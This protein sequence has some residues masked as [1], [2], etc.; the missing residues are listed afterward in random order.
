MVNDWLYVIDAI[1]IVLFFASYYLHCYRRGYKIDI[2]YTQLFLGCVLVDQVMLPFA[3]SDLNVISIGALVTAV[4]D[5]LADAFLISLVGFFAILA[6]GALWKLRLGVGLRR[7]ASS[8]LDILP[9]QSR[10]LM[11]SRQL[12][13]LQ[14]VL[15]LLAQFVIVLVY[16]KSSGF[17]FN[18]RKFA[19]EEPSI[20]P[21]ALAISNY[22]IIIASHC[23]ARYMDTKEKSLLACTFFLTCGLLFFGSRG[24]ILGIFF[25]VLLCHLMRL[26][27][28]LKL[29]R[30]ILIFF[31]VLFFGLYVG[32]LR[33]GI[34]SMSLFMSGVVIEIFYGNSFS[35]LRDFSLVLSSW[36]GHLW[37]GQTYLAAA[38]AFV[39]RFLSTYRD[40]WSIGVVTATMA[41]FDP[42]VHPGLRTGL[43]GEA[44]LNFGYVGVVLM[45]SLIGIVVRKVDTE[46]KKALAGEHP[47]ISRAFS[48]TILLGVTSALAISSGASTVYMLLLVYGVSAFARRML[49]GYQALFKQRPKIQEARGFQQ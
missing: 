23:F 41:G 7:A 46:A 4:Q 25:A 13:V 36:N 16:F 2:W 35:D 22:S 49:A 33:A 30:V 1:V 19:F 32:A 10:L 27:R 42:K 11:S 21:I 9:R 45:G 31:A 6:G 26:R 43:F 24:S 14:A 47:S 8:I 15:C 12:L 44:Y 38:F 40:T 37:L 18:L 48:H 29:R 5:H 3:G 39:P 28:R 20:R 34:Y 17:G